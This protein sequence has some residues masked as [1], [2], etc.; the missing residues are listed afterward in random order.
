V[1]TYRPTVYATTSADFGANV[2]VGA[3]LA[4]H[5]GFDL[6]LPHEIALAATLPAQPRYAAYL[7]VRQDIMFDT[8]FMASNLEC[9]KLS[10]RFVSRR[11]GRVEYFQPPEQVLCAATCLGA[12]LRVCSGYRL[13]A[14]RP[15]RQQDF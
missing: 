6:R 2:C 14:A 10:Q 8:H 15:H 3:A 11:V 12:V 7:L 1:A 4:L 9:C 13:S 5:H